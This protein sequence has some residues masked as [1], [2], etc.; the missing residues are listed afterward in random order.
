MRRFLRPTLRR[1]LPRRLLP[2]NSSRWLFSLKSGSATEQS[3]NSDDIGQS[4]CTDLWRETRQ[5]VHISGKTPSLWKLITLLT[6]YP[7][8]SSIPD[9]EKIGNR[10]VLGGGLEVAVASVNLGRPKEHSGLPTLIPAAILFPLMG[11]GESRLALL[12]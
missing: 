6:I 4:F 5:L 11:L 10:E 8:F 9:C 1:P 7:S 12:L 2:M 3:T